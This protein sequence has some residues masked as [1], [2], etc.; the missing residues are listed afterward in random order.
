MQKV[1]CK[2]LSDLVMFLEMDEQL[3]QKLQKFEVEFE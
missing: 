1:G 3:E 2:S